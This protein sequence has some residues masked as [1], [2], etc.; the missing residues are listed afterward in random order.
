M[1]GCGIRIWLLLLSSVLI[2]QYKGA[3]LG[4]VALL[5]NVIREISVLLFTPIMVRYFGKIS[6]ICAAGVTSVD[7]CL[8]IITQYAGKEMLIMAIVNGILTDI[9][10]PFLVMLFI[11]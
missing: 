1:Y 8:P 7:T 9:S 6:P 5:S 4:A 3:E 11:A 2:T 10:I